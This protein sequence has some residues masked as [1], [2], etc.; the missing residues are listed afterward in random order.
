MQ[1]GSRC[2]L[3]FWM[4]NAFSLFLLSIFAAALALPQ[5]STTVKKKTSTKTAAKKTASTRSAKSTK[6]A[7]TGKKTVKSASRGQ[8]A[9]TPERYREI[10]Q[11]LADKG[12]LKA[13]PSGVWDAASAEA[14]SRFQADRKLPVTGKINSASLIGLG[15][16][17]R[18]A[19]ADPPKPAATPN[20]AP[21][22]APPPAPLTIPPP[23][24]P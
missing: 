2:P 11:A 23:E 1:G 19:A 21:A 17:P 24:N 14:L 12:Y 8:M 18:T 3:S 22:G 5:S 10:Q 16:G 7:R 6:K 15:L 9:P 20:Q 4:K 13:D